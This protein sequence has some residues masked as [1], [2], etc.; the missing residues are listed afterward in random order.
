MAMAIQ[1]TTGLICVAKGAVWSGGVNGVGGGVEI[2]DP[3]TQTFTHYSKDLN[4]RVASLAF[5]PDGTLWATTWP[6]RHQVVKFNIQ[7]RAEVML[8]FDA[9]IDSLAFGQKGTAL[10]GLLFVSQNTGSNDYSGS[11]LTMIDVATLRRVAVADGG[12]RGDV[13][14]T[15]HDG[16]VLVSQS[17][18]VDVINQATAPVVIATSPPPSAV[19]ALP[20]SQVVI[21]FDQDMFSGTG[22]EL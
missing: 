1:P 22:T 19:V 2:F 9:D 12:T 4:L 10:E 7:R 16:R 11:E 18:Q 5:A 20:L 21:T 6:D 3:N 15:T 17:N 13:L 14:I 8:T